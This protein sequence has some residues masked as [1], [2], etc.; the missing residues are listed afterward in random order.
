MTMTL[1]MCLSAHP[2]MKM[3]GLMWDYWTRMPL[4]LMPLRL[5]AQGRSQK[6]RS[7]RSGK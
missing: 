3:K 6:P 5:K 7:K 2:P 1:E 4:L